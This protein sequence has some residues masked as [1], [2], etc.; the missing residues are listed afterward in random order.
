MGLST[1]IA[2]FIP[3]CVSIALS[4]VIF[5]QCKNPKRRMIDDGYRVISHTDTIR[6]RTVDT[7]YVVGATKIVT[8]T[9]FTDKLYINDSISEWSYELQEDDLIATMYTKS[10]GV[11]YEQSLEYKIVYPQIKIQDSIIIKRV[12]SIFIDPKLVNKFYGG[13]D[14][15]G[16]KSTIGMGVSALWQTKS[17]YIFSLGANVLNTNKPFFTLGMKIPLR[18]K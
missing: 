7:M 4:L 15:H 13:I 17:D 8:K 1:N 2:K 16:S 10:S 11:V 9:V 3:W 12:D 18:R 5:S 6:T 14:I